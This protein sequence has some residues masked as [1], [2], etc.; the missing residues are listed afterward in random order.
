MPPPE[1]VEEVEYV[2]N[3]M[4]LPISLF[5]RNDKYW[6]HDNARTIEAKDYIH[7]RHE[8]DRERKQKMRA[9]RKKKQMER[10]KRNQQL[11]E[12]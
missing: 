6:S 12:K 1:M 11:M 5:K 3:N 4:D 8:L 9:E 2:V 7:H 10:D